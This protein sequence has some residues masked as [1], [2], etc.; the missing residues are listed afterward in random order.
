MIVRKKT[1]KKIVFAWRRLSSKW[2]T[3]PHFVIIG[4]QKSGTSSLHAYLAQHPQILPAS[5]KEVHYFSGGSG[6]KVDNYEKGLL[7]Y[8]AHFPLKRQLSGGKISFEATPVYLFHPEVPQRIFEALPKAKLIVLLRDPAERAISHYYFDNKNRSMVLPIK[9]AMEQEEEL[10]SEILRNNQ[11]KDPLFY[12]SSYKSR[13]LYYD[14]IKRYL[15]Y[16]PKE[17]LLIIDSESL[18]DETHQTL[19]IIFAFLG[20]DDK[21][22]ISDTQPRRVNEAKEK[23]GPEIYQYLND[24]FAKP[25]QLLFELIGERFDWG[26]SR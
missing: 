4:A 11:Y 8:R 19:K 6:Q 18:F 26:K 14:Q 1:I 10:L 25:N 22:T 23:P 7:W 2:R 20:I 21:L 15:K 13:G 12:G 9:N 16:F 17:Q 5:R 3:L 24:Y